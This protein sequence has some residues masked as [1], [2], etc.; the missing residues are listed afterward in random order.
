MA[1]RL[2]AVI[3]DFDG[4]LV[5]TESPAFAAWSA[6]YK[7]HGVALELALWV[8]CVGATHEAFDPVTHLASLTGRV[9]DRAGLF[10]DKERRKADICS[11]LP[12]MPGALARLEEA[13]T[14]GL[15]VA[16]ASGS[17]A[18]WVKGHLER[19][20]ILYRFDAVRTRDDVA[21][22]KPFPD[23]ILSA[24]AAMG[25]AP[26]ACLVLE[27]SLNGILA[28]KAAGARCYAIPNDITRALDFSGADGRFASLEAVSFRG[29]PS[30]D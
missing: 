8:K 5:D 20:G 17:S 25:V 21:R 22:V 3:F 11:R 24:A 4:L 26:E 2:Q 16:V 27:D 19:L 13:R 15:K 7:E 12:L 30:P 6:I 18:A 9:H 23:L 29:S 28:A 10:A 14:L 1:T